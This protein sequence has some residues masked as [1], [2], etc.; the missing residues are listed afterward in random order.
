MSTTLETF[1]SS[2]LSLH[3]STV[4]SAAERSPVLVTRRDAEDL[5][6]MSERENTARR[7][8]MEFAAQII[9]VTTDERGTLAER[10]SNIFPW[11]LALSPAGRVKCAT[12]L[13]EAA[14]ASFATGQ[15]H[16]ALAEKTS[17][18]E[19]AIN[20]AAGLGNEASDWLDQSITVERP[21]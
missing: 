6:L 14:R 15:I 1:R 16:L 19:T 21:E 10:M 11:M 18:E 9:A 7:L 4:Y 12:A 3:S 17:W 13:V 8:L 2:D 5:V 20:M